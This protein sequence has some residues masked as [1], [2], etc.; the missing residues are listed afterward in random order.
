M[1]S[2]A[3]SERASLVA[4]IRKVIDNIVEIEIVE[5]DSVLARTAMLQEEAG[6]RMKGLREL[7]VSL[8]E[9]LRRHCQ[10]HGCC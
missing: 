4:E 8:I 2:P 10:E 6:A 9:K 7:K 3:C 1:F 5:L